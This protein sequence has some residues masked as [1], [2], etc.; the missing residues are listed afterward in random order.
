MTNCFEVHLGFPNDLASAAA[1]RSALCA[2]QALHS[3]W[4][5]S[6]VRAVHVKNPG[7]MDPHNVPGTLGALISREFPVWKGDNGR[8]D[9]VLA[10]AQMVLSKMATQDFA[11]ARLEIE[12]PFGCFSTQLDFA[13]QPVRMSVLGDSRSIAPSALTFRD[14]VPVAETPQWEIH[15]VVDRL[16]EHPSSNLG[17]EQ[18][19]L[20]IE[21]YGVDIEQT[22]EYRS[23][24]M[25]ER[26]DTGYK[27]ISTSYYGSRDQTEAAG[28]QLFYH[29]DLCS[30]FLQRGYSVKL[31]LEHIVG[32]FRPMCESVKDVGVRNREIV[33]AK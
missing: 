17:I 22:I 20:I 23:Q 31:I 2:L 33:H 3:D 11:N 5:Y 12:Y 1:A 28:R 26:G 19:P 6:E 16:H 10:E 4:T 8:P 30:A 7:C 9:Q 25:S 32:C 14:A 18:V 15:F 24:A 29:T 13:G 21:A 27:F